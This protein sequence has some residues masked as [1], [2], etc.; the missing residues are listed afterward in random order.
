MGEP[1]PLRLSG[2][3]VHSGQQGE[4]RI[5]L[6][7]GLAQNPTFTQNPGITENTMEAGPKFHF[8]DFP[9]MQIG[10]LG[11][12][13]RRA[14]RATILFGA[15]T[16]GTP[17]H[18]L[19]ALLFF[20][21]QPL[22]IHCNISELPGLDGSALS[23]REIL[24]QLAPQCA[25]KPMWKEYPCGLHWDH[26]WGYGHLRVRPA[27]KFRVR[28][29]L[30]RL[31]LRQSFLLEDPIVAWREILPARSFVFYREWEQALSAGLM[32]GAGLE[33]GLL[34]A[35]SETE[36]TTL[37]ADHGD[38]QGGPFPLLNQTGW[39]MQDE[40]VKHKILDLLG[41][42]ALAGLALPKLDIEIRN[43]G[44]SVHHLLLEK[45]SLN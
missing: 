4:L 12:L 26:D 27:P 10:D 2:S 9:A 34:L 31:S 41:D 23:F 32:Q 30:D 17:E 44:H 5:S 22:D 19:A 15:G 39:R 35:E 6:R 24:A 20:S 3:G 42:L 18:L 21:D 7:P 14:Q 25:S 13:S 36:H 8:P 40:P 43:G 45:L 37:L 11:R 1:Q 16:L 38:W 28:Y 29:T 33:S